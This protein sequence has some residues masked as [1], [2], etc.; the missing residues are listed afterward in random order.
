MFSVKSA[1][2][3]A[4]F[5]Y[6]SNC[7]KFLP[8]YITPCDLKNSDYADCIK[9][10]I[11][12][13]L[14]KFTKGIPELGVAS[15]DPVDLDDIHVDGNGLKLTFTKAQMHGLGDAKLSKLKVVITKSNENFTLA[16]KSDLMLTAK[17]EINGRIIILP[18]EGQGDAVVKCKNVEVSIDGTLARSKNNIGEHLKLITPKYQYDIEKTTFRFENLF[19]GSKTL[20]DT[21][22]Q[23][24]NE[25]WQ[26]LMDDLAPPIIKQ[27]VKTII[28]SI[29]KFFGSVTID[30]I[31][32]NY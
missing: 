16:F 1:V 6:S 11:E 24:A 17:Y 31:L 20:S 30:Q 7:Q 13:A 14:P 5:L 3:L 28:K 9:E 23:F 29:N 32:K 4:A 2:F 27:I 10:Q 22:H 25:N 18:I 8:A 26:Q 15:T 19:N 21:T 12:I